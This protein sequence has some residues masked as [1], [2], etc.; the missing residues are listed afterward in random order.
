[1][2]RRALLGIVGLLVLAMTMSGCFGLFGPKVGQVNGT[3]KY[4]SGTPIPNADVR[5]GTETIK[6][7]AQGQFSFSK[8]KHGTYDFTVTVGGEV[9]HTQKVT[10]GAKP[11]TINVTVDDPVQ[12]GTISGMVT[13]ENGTPIPGVTVKLGDKSTTTT[14]EGN[15]E[16]VDIPYGN[17]TVKAEVD[18]VEYSA[19][20]NL[21]TSS[22]VVNIVVPDVV[23]SGNL[24]GMV[25]DAIG[26]PVV[27]VTVEIDGWQ[28]TAPDGQFFFEDLPFGTYELKVII[29]GE[30]LPAGQV[31]VDAPSVE[32]DI[33]VEV[34]RLMGTVR[35]QHHNPV[36]GA[37]VRLHTGEASTT[38]E[39][40]TYSFINLL[41]RAYDLSVVVEDETLAVREVA[42]EQPD[43]AYDVEVVLPGP[44]LV[45]AEDFSGTATDPTA[46]GWTT[47]A[48]WTIAERDGSRWIKSAHEAETRA[49]IEIP[50]FADARV[51]IVEYKTVLQVGAA[52]AIKI[53]ADDPFNNNH[54][55]GTNF[56]FSVVPPNLVMRMHTNG[57]YPGITPNTGHHVL[58]ADAGFQ[59]DEV[60][61]I[62]VVYDRDARKLDAYVNGVQVVDYPWDLPDDA[63]EFDED[64]TYL[65]LH[66]N[67]N[68][69]GLWTD[70]KVWVE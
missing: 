18:G 12:T 34:G 6:T 39:S 35:D 14:A 37:E 51:V 55:G 67:T 4:K 70:L 45:Y 3:V 69:T 13:Y 41:Y 24:S 58:T 17:Y 23:S 7:N 25:K 53:L 68:S 43:V 21:N 38:D 11:A 46:F 19:P 42:V 20:A 30:V 44:Q 63:P 1:M 62:R 27:G 2:R 64:N 10:V 28:Q 52:A 50:D 49:Y 54:R 15:Y 47:L 60:Y 59:R 33:E 5:L 56:S 66:S 65:M 22:L 8:I 61:D 40:G 16:F 36:V 32:Y 9:V 31:T 29:Q 48:G 26:R 57:N